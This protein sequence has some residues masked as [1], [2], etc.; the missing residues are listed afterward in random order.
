MCWIGHDG[1]FCPPA[2]PLPPI[3]PAHSCSS[4]QSRFHRCTTRRVWKSAPN[5]RLMWILTSLDVH[6]TV[7]A[8]LSGHV[9]YRDAILVHPARNQPVTGPDARLLID[10]SVKASDACALEEPG[11]HLQSCLLFHASCRAACRL[12]CRIKK[13]L[14]LKNGFCHVLTME[15]VDHVIISCQPAGFRRVGSRVVLTVPLASLVIA[16]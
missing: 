7:Q 4:W 8:R 5:L 6:G 11:S 9:P 12:T 1:D 16:H 13:M 10:V 15:H 3:I 14:L 2:D